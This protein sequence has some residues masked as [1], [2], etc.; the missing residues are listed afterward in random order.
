MPNG[1]KTQH[2]DHFKAINT[3]GSKKVD[4]CGHD[5][6]TEANF[7]ALKNYVPGVQVHRPLVQT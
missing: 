1:V 4:E 2:L 3:R 6:S 7:T 5:N